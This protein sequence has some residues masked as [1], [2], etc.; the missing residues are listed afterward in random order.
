MPNKQFRIES[1]E[2]FSIVGYFSDS[3]CHKS[4]KQNLTETE[5]VP[6]SKLPVLEEGSILH[7]EDIE[8]KQIRFIN[9]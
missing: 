4:P 3:F 9:Y 8:K 7:A 2:I 1:Q 6:A 5:T